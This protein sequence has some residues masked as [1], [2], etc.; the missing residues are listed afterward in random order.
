MARHTID[1][2]LKGAPETMHQ[3]IV[4]K[5]HAQD[6]LVEIDAELKRLRAMRR[7]WNRRLG[8]CLRRMAEIQT[9]R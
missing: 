6:R 7:A 8:V 4:E 9:G 5:C 3:A 2:L 1:P